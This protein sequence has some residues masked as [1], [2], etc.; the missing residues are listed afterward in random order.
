MDIEIITTRKKLSLSFLKQM[1]QLSYEDFDSVEV[2]GFVT[3]G[4][5]NTNQSALCCT[6]DYYLLNMLWEKR[7]N[8]IGYNFPGFRGEYQKKFKD[9]IKIDEWFEKYTK[10]VL[11]AKLKGHIYI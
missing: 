6:D 3:V 9:E 5:K 11:E 10:I 2:L 1:F 8:Y 7:G 4:R